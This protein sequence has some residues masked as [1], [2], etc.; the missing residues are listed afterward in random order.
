MGI[1]VVA[2]I[3]DVVVDQVLLENQDILVQVFQDIPGQVFLVIAGPRATLENQGTQE[4]QDNLVLYL[5]DPD[6]AEPPAIQENPVIVEPPAIQENPVCPATQ[7]NLE[8]PAIPEPQVIVEPLESPENR[9]IRELQ[10]N[11]VLYQV[12]QVIVE[13]LATQENPVYPA[14]QELQVTQESP[15][16]PA[17]Q[18][19]QVTQESPVLPV[20]QELELQDIQEFPVIQELVVICPLKIQLSP[21]VLLS[22]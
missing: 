5:V 17:T 10:D 15:V 20:T 18:E 8:N 19:L 1:L 22:V 7:E 2:V 11:L 12:D 21:F 16:Y 14:T 13:L 9:V 3:L 4:L 6:I